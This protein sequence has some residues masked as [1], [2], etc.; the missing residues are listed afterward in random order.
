M[1]NCNN[2]E[3][4]EDRL[5]LDCAKER[6]I[7]VTPTSLWTQRENDIDGEATGDRNVTS[8][9]L[10]T[11]GTVLAIGATYDNGNGN[12]RRLCASLLFELG[13]L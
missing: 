4:K 11:C 7:S 9:N 10:N 1:A 6:I 2:A 5:F 3:D 8:V 12:R 13:T